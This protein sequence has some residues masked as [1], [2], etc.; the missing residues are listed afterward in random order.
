MA[1]LQLVTQGI[2]AGYDEDGFFAFGTTVSHEFRNHD[3]HSGTPDIQGMPIQ[4]RI[5]LRGQDLFERYQSL[6]RE[7]DGQSSRLPML[8]D[9][10]VSVQQRPTGC[11]RRW[12]HDEPIALSY[13][14]PNDPSLAAFVMGAVAADRELTIWSGGWLFLT[15]DKVAPAASIDGFMQRAEPAFTLDAPILRVR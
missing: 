14:F 15:E 13:S 6:V 2:E 11:L 8:Q 4:W 12:D 10:F 5:N 1:N 7:A 9:Y 3:W